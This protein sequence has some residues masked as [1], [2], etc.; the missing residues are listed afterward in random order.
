MQV[1]ALEAGFYNGAPV[2][3]GQT[4]TVKEGSKARWYAPVENEG[5]KP[6]ASAPTKAKQADTLS[7]MGKEQTET[8]T[9]VNAK[10]DKA[11]LA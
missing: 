9:D 6:K 8:F 3:K 4:F 5:S 1:V 7:A 2:A 10:D 11:T